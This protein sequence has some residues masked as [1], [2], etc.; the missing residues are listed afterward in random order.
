MGDYEVIIFYSILLTIST[1]PFFVK[2]TCTSFII[3][4]IPFNK[5]TKYG[6]FSSMVLPFPA[7]KN[8]LE[9]EMKCWKNT[10]NF[11][12]ESLLYMCTCYHNIIYFIEINYNGGAAS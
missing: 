5:H 12:S 2:F 4:Y 11:D 6:L 10:L 9:D 1:S 8:K 7:Q 3:A